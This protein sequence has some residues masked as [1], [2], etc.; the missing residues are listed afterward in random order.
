MALFEQR[1][2]VDSLWR[3]VESAQRQFVLRALSQLVGFEQLR[4]LLA[5]LRRV[6]VPVNRDGVLDCGIEKLALAIGRNR[7]RA[8]VVARVFATVDM[9][10]SHPILPRRV[11]AAS[12]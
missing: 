11:L 12:R 3:I 4:Q 2:I 9:H 10:S 7:D 6:L 5:E 8:V 1:P